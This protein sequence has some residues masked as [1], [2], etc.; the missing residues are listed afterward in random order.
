[1]KPYRII[2]ATLTKYSGEKVDLVIESEIITRPV[3][4][5]KE[6]LLDAICKTYNSPHD[7]FVKIDLKT[8]GLFNV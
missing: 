7:P 1:M 6:M 5:M 4:I 3:R 2:A 8:Q